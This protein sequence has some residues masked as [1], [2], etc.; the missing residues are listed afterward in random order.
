MAPP[1]PPPAYAPRP[2]TPT[3]HEGGAPLPNDVIILPSGQMAVPNG[4]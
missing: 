1:A 2:Y 4:R 3:D